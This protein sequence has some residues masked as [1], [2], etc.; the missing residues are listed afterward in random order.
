[1]NEIK[2]GIQSASALS[3]SHQWFAQLYHIFPHFLI[4]AAI[5]EKENDLT[6]KV[7]FYFLYDFCLEHFS[8]QEE[9]NYTL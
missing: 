5:F 9:F 4:I 8:F 3:Y 1:M 2:S 7:C 6:Q